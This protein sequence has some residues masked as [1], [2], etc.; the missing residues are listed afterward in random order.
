[1]TPDQ[2]SRARD[3]RAAVAS[4]RIEGV[5]ITPDAMEIFNAYV[6]GDIDVDELARQVVALITRSSGGIPVVSRACA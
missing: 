5:V 1:M 6:A 3:V 4:A 2:E